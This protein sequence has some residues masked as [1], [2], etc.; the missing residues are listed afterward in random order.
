[1]VQ[2][3]TC[4]GRTETQYHGFAEVAG[5][6]CVR[7]KTTDKYVIFN[8]YVYTVVHYLYF[9]YDVI[10]PVFSQQCLEVCN[11]LSFTPMISWCIARI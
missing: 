2:A 7:D 1:M 11:R 8:L 5:I 3:F 4:T 9:F 6:G 10:F